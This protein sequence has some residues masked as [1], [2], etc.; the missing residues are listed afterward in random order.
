MLVFDAST[1]SSSGR[2][3][4]DVLCTGL[5]LQTDLHDIIFRYRLY[6]YIITADIIKMNRKILIH[7]EDRQFQHISCNT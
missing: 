3:L 5:K 4:K 7:A 1:V 6:K 2:L